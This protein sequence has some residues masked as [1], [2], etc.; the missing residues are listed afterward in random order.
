MSIRIST[1][2]NRAKTLNE[3]LAIGVNH[4]ITD[5]MPNNVSHA[6]KILKSVFERDELLELAKLAALQQAATLIE[7]FPLDKPQATS[8]E[9]NNILADVILNV[10]RDNM[11]LKIAIEETVTR[12]IHGLMG[13]EK[14]KYLRSPW[15]DK[16]QSA[17]QRATKMV[18]EMPMPMRN[19]RFYMDRSEDASAITVMDSMSVAWPTFPL[20]HKM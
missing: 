5:Q 6:S 17:I 7:K 15:H 3:V 10:L 4:S 18:R 19:D 2:A 16:S 1:V 20:Q 13:R 14:Y 12:V 11:T 9:I 8:A